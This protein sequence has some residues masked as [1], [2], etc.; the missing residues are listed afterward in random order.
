MWV[1]MNI[2]D[3]PRIAIFDGENDEPS[4]GLGDTLSDK[5]TNAPLWP[6]ENVGI[7]PT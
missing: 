3:T 1:C 2:W 5:P 6:L 7:Y 4:I